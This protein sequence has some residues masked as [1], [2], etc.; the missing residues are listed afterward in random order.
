[1]MIQIIPQMRIF[2]CVEPQLRSQLNVLL[3]AQPAQEL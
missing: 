3:H 2:L 1:M